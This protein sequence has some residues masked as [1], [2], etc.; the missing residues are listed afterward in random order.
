[1]R[2][3]YN[4]DS[5]TQNRKQVAGSTAHKLQEIY[6]KTLHFWNLVDT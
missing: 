4:H 6:N 5:G 3:T 1:M 2:E